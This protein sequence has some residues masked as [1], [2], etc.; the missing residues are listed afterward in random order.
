MKNTLLEDKNKDKGQNKIENKDKDQ[1]EMK[2]IRMRNQ[3]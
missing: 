1:G 2:I 3:E